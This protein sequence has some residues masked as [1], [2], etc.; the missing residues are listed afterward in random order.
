[1]RSTGSTS[2][3]VRPI[4]AASSTRL[5]QA[6]GAGQAAQQLVERVVAAHVLPH[7]LHAAIGCHPGGGVC[8]TAQAV[9]R[10]I[11]GQLIERACQCRA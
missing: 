7:E 4:S 6:A 3:R 11:V 10:L 1:M 2:P 5:S 8:A 9:Q